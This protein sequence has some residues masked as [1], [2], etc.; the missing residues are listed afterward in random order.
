MEVNRMKSKRDLLIG[1]TFLALLAALAV[2]HKVLESRAV[3]EAAG[4]QAPMFE[5]DPLWPRPLPNHWVMG[6][7][8]GVSVDAQDHVWIIHR[9]SSLEPKEIYASTNPPGASCCLPAPPVLEFDQAGSLIGHWGGPGQ[10]YE[11]PESNHGITVDYKG[12][13]WIGGNGRGTAP[14]TAAG[15]RGQP[16]QG[17]PPP[18]PQTAGALGYFHDS[19]IMKFTQD[20]KFLMQIGK[21]GASKGSNDVENLRLPAKIFVDKDTNE[22]YVADGYGNHR[23]IVYDADS[24]K[25]KRHWGA[26]GH[27]PEDVNLGNYDPDAPP[28]Q[29][30]RNPVHCA[31]LAKDGLLY[32]CDRVNDRIQV[33]KKD[34]TFVKE[35]F[36]A[37]RTLGDGSVWDIA[38]SRDPQQKYLY[39]ADGAN[40]KIYIMLRDSLEILTSFGDGGRQP[41]QFY[42]VHS[43]ATDSKGNIYTTETYRGQRVQRFM[44]KGIGT[45]A[46]MDQGVLWPRSK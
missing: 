12:N 5:V 14:G 10:G 19:M 24:G 2:S 36:I 44:Y 30:F 42:A 39:L 21:A 6:N 15:G 45:V 3:A 46:K 11:W 22:V 16:A 43:I 31:E 26:Y 29:Q 4:V 40:E 34:G 38:F 37:K 33:F 17:T 35:V 9:Q 23:V 20:G 25:Y 41:G 28:A 8:I 13:V 18:E 1:V 32:V 7:T 27:K